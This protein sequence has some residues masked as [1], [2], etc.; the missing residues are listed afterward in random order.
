VDKQDLPLKALDVTMKIM[1]CLG[2]RSR[3][4][5]YWQRYILKEDI[6]NEVSRE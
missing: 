3:L 6:L 1:D 5:G 4:S 2:Q